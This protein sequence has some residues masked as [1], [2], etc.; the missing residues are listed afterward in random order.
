MPLPKLPI[1]PA[2]LIKAA[3]K[4]FKASEQPLQ[5]LLAL[6]PRLDPALAQAL[7][8][9]LVSEVDTTTVAVVGLSYAGDPGT[10]A[11]SIP[12]G[13]GCVVACT[14]TAELGLEAYIAGK[15]HSVPVLIATPEADILRQAATEANLALPAHQTCD[16]VAGPLAEAG[17]RDAVGAV[18]TMLCKALKKQRLGL[19]RAFAFIRE[20]YAHVLA[21]E[22]ALRNTAVAVLPVVPG[23]DLP[24]LTLNQAIMIVQ[25]ALAYGIRIDVARIKEALWL[26]ASAYGCRTVA[27]VLAGRIPLLGWAIRGGV[28][29][30]ATMALGVAASA[31]YAQQAAEQQPKPGLQAAAAVTGEEA[32]NAR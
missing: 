21:Q 18:A 6:D 26:V 19:A 13:T 24:V 1:N 3:L 32:A 30:S 5:I 20:P 4:A 31:Y 7:A 8:R 11:L 2:S 22:T 14:T 9:A 15:L 29:Y 16:I 23:A 25:I 28:G 12:A 10:P 27:R 17:I